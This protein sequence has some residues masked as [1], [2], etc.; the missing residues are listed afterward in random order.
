MIINNNDKLNNYM[1]SKYIVIKLMSHYYC[2]W[3]IVLQ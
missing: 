1:L 3:Q 2:L